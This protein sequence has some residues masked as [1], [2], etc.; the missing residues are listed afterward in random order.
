MY[1]TSGE[2]DR[3]EITLAI[4]G[5]LAEE[6]QD[7]V[8]RYGQDV[9][10]EIGRQAAFELTHITRHFIHDETAW[11]IQQVNRTTR[12][13]VRR[14][15]TE[16]LENRESFTQITARVKEIFF[17]DVS[18]Y[19]ARM[20]GVTES[21]KA[22]GFAANEAFAQAG[23]EKK[24]WLAVMDNYTRDTHAAMDGQ[25][26]PADS[27]FISPSGDRAQYPGGFSTAAENI[28]CRCT[29][30]AVFDDEEKSAAPV[31]RV[32]QWERREA[33]RLRAE[34]KL[35]SISHKIFTMQGEAVLKRMGQ[36]HQE[37]GEF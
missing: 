25:K 34:K 27:Y 17:G 9:A 22:T 16:A 21:T 11:L 28:N 7:I 10:E 24:E 37:P 8:A 3:P 14:A 12:E 2:I 15:I 29:T 1:F 20:I 36:V 4:T 26:V 35:V 30:V 23:I 33:A 6:L 13:M 32:A 31:D 18:D 5:L 19:R